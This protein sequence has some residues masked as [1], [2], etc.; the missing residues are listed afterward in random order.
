MD[1]TAGY[2]SDIEYVAGFYREQSPTYLNFV[3]VI[4]GFEPVPLNRPF[5]YFELGFGRGFTVNLLAASH[6]QGNFFAT[7]FNPA[8]VAGA[9]HLAATAQLG[10]LTLLENS[11]EDLAAGQVSNLPQFDFITL[12][13][14]YTWV[15]AENR[16]HISRFIARYLKP[17][18]IVYLSYNA[19]PGWA[20]ALPLQRMLVEHADLHPDRSD[21]QIRQASEFVEK[22]CA[23]EAAYFQTNPSLAPRLEHLQTMSP[24][25]LVH[26][27]MHRHWQPMY[28]TDV[29]R[30]MSIAKLDFVGCA[31]LAHAYPS[32]Y[33]TPESQA[34]LHSISDLNVR[35][36]TK[37]YFLNTSFRK[38]VFVRGA[39]KMSE[40]RQQEWMQQVGLA[41]TVP[42]ADINLIMNLAVVEVGAKEENY[43]PVLDILARQPSTLLELAAAT[44]QSIDDLSRIAAVL[45][46]AKNASVYF[47]HN[48][49]VAADPAHKINRLVATMTQ[50][51]DD[52]EALTSPL[53]GNGVPL[54]YL[55]RMVFLVLLEHPKKTDVN[56]IAKLVWTFFEAQGRCVM[57]EGKALETEEESLAELTNQ[58]RVILTKKVP[59]WRQLKLL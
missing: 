10:N 31:E 12:H 32:M 57:I 33:L 50:H 41:L 30:D 36:T 15:T 5:T 13:G 51:G 53:I 52:Y 1:W 54:T 24:N 21:V 14:I 49:E 42:R 7:D 9:Q 38:D 23:A 16:Q 8:H 4:N 28:H 58:A 37:D 11:F 43:G 55:E 34:L 40:T 44:G 59:V 2:A 27:Y 17:G 39:R 18:G 29:A 47:T 22:M 46:A 35:E 6:P 20:T 25:Y 48:L 26:E 56:T 19:M 45:M 3:C